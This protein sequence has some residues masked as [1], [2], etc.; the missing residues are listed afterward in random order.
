MAVREKE[1]AAKERL[2]EQV[3]LSS[4]KEKVAA[5][6]KDKS[7]YEK[8][9]DDQNEKIELLKLQHSEKIEI[10]QNVVLSLQEEVSTLKTE[11]V[12][13][14]ASFQTEH[15]K[16]TELLASLDETANA[17]K[18]SKVTCS[19]TMPQLG[20]NKTEKEFSQ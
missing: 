8:H 14:K 18:A 12:E 1:D 13:S 16:V 4:L 9:F 11:V 15:D 3:E 17:L 5:L 6:E 20:T 2:E 19:F 10:N 7:E